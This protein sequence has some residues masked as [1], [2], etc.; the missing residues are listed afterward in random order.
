MHVQIS[1]IILTNFKSYYGQVTIDIGERF[2]WFAYLS[3]IMSSIV[4][5][6]GSGK[7]ALMDALCW[8]FGS[9]AP[10]IRTE[11]SS[12]L[13]NDRS[14]AEGNREVY[15]FVGS[16]SNRKAEI[17]F[18]LSDIASPPLGLSPRE[19]FQSIP[20]LQSGNSK[21]VITVG[22]RLHNR[23]M[24]YY[25][26]FGD[27]EP[28]LIKFNDISMIL[29]ALQI[30]VNMRGK[31]IIQQS[32]LLR[33]L[34]QRRTSLLEMIE[35]CIGDQAIVSLLE[36]L[37]KRREALCIQ[38]E[39]V[40]SRL[41]EIVQYAEEH[42][43]ERLLANRVRET[44]K[45]VDELRKEELVI[46]KKER[47]LR[48]TLLIKL[49]EDYPTVIRKKEAKMRKIDGEIDSV[50][51]QITEAERRLTA[52]EKRKRIA[53]EKLESFQEGL[54]LLESERQ[55][56]KRELRQEQEKLIHILDQEKEVKK[57]L[58]RESQVQSEFSHN[59]GCTNEEI[60][61]YVEAYKVL[62]RERECSKEIDEL[63]RVEE[64]LELKIRKGKEKEKEIESKRMV[65]REIHQIQHR[66]HSL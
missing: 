25:G 64:E 17:Q 4:G 27:S 65:W 13:I 29:E 21:L 60:T 66:I 58:E 8:I 59:V 31:F 50:S 22:R 47:G 46:R 44:E 42:K 57:N 26:R 56:L 3:S 28:F 9:R 61:E 10:A 37:T 2:V 23:A 49:E 54:A 6:N 38:K 18:T 36:D 14:R 12:Q 43:S 41:E 11:N 39:S 51:K 35:E 53:D 16:F 7:S 1:R 34:R 19:A 20:K 45:N 5:K 62:Q 40:R 33:N 32:E 15:D 30:Q 55:R 63:E 48:R 24:D 52:V